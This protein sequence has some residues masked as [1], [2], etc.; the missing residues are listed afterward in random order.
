MV[1]INKYVKTILSEIVVEELTIHTEKYF[2]YLD[3]YSNIRDVIVNLKHFS[4]NVGHHLS[5]VNY[6]LH[7]YWNRFRIRFLYS[8]FPKSLRN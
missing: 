1:N 7:T 2:Q 4:T 6:F 8:C 3:W 5:Y